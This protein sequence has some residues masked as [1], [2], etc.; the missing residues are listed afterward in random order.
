MEN[1]GWSDGQKEIKCRRDKGRPV[2]FE[3]QRAVK[4]EEHVFPV[5]KDCK[6]NRLL[7]L[8]IMEP[9]GEKKPDVKMHLY[10]SC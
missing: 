5:G 3:M 7:K 1:S 4:A 10:F 6:E 9:H 8:A 2:W